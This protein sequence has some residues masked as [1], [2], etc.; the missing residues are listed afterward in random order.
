MILNPLYLTYFKVYYKSVR[1]HDTS[2]AALN[3]LQ[4]TVFLFFEKSFSSIYIFK[5]TNGTDING[6]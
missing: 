1:C 3:G 4:N 2:L 5:R 6:N